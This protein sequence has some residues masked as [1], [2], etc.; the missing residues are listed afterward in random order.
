M[1]APHETRID[2]DYRCKKCGDIPIPESHHKMKACTCGAIQVD[3]G[4]YGGRVLWSGGTFDECVEKI[5]RAE[6]GSSTL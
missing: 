4:W 6:D 3:R 2:Y 1:T 5:E